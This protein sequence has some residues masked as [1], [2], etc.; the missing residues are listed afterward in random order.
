M[1]IIDGKI[2]RIHLNVNG[3]IY[4]YIPIQMPL[5]YKSNSAHMVI[6][7]IELMVMPISEQISFS[8][9]KDD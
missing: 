3:Q 2:G 9:K 7:N 6:E 1:Y 5:N 8:K 4:I